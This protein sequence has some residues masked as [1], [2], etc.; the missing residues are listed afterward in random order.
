MWFSNQ[1]W[2]SRLASSLEGEACLRAACTPMLEFAVVVVTSCSLF[3]FGPF[4]WQRTTHADGTNNTFTSYSFSS[5]SPKYPAKS[6]N[7]P[8]AEEKHGLLVCCQAVFRTLVWQSHSQQDQEMSLLV[9]ESC[10]KSKNPCKLSG[11]LGSSANI[12]GYQQ[13]YTEKKNG[14]NRATTDFFL[15]KL[16]FWWLNFIEGF[17]RHH[18]LYQKKSIYHQINHCNKKWS[19]SAAP[20][21]LNSNIYN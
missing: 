9:L 21:P 20:A 13:L 11:I 1:R 6:M 8:E 14:E 18:C 7:T 2:S 15:V 5:P 4:S 17:Q 3:F 12:C 10:S 19:I 16:T